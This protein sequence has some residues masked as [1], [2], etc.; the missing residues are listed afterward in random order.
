[1]LGK[2]LGVEHRGD[3]S[4]WEQVWVALYWGGMNGPILGNWHSLLS[5]YAPELTLPSCGSHAGFPTFYKNHET[6]TQTDTYGPI[7]CALLT[8]KHEEHRE[9]KHVG[10]VH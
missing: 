2:G 10:M 4:P 5:G 6:D 3:K 7:M 9:H 1:V 8:T